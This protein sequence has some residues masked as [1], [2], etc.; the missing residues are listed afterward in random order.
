MIFVSLESVLT[1][2]IFYSLW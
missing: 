2:F 1:R